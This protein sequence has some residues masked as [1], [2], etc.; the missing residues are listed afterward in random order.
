MST[1]S[2]PEQTSCSRPSKIKITYNQE[3]SI[4][5]N[6]AENDLDLWASAYPA[7]NLNAELNSMCAWLKANPKNLKSNYERFI[8]SWLK[9][10]QDKARRV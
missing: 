2:C 3:K 4:F 7:I 9:R 10:S 5:E 6:I 1:Y 8:I